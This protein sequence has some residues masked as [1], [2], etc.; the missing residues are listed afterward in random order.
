MIHKLGW[1]Y[2]IHEKYMQVHYNSPSP[3]ILFL[4]S[5]INMSSF[6]LNASL[7]RMIISNKTHQPSLHILFSLVGLLRTSKRWFCHDSLSSSGWKWHVFSWVTTFLKG[8]L[9]GPF[10]PW[11]VI[12]NVKCSG[13]L[14]IKSECMALSSQELLLHSFFFSQM[15]LIVAV[16]KVIL[17]ASTLSLSSGSRNKIFDFFN[18]ILSQY[19]KF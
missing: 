19:L 7:Y 8:M 13:F 14:F 18:I 10:L 9:F 1:V 5:M 16:F 3:L 2:S 4:C 11:K 6:K 15:N 17:L 12:I